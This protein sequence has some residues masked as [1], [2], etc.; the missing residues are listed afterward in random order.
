MAAMDTFLNILEENRKGVRRG[1]YSVCSSQ[2]EV[3]LAAL[4]QALEDQGPVIIES[5]SNQVDQFG[6]Y[7]GMT[8]AGFIAFVENL[9][10]R[11]GFPRERLLFGGD[12]LG[13]NRWQGLKAETAM[14]H[15]FKLVNDYVR[16]GYRK[17]H[18]DASMFCADDP[19]DRTK[20]LDD[21]IVARRA[22]ALC[23]V[24]EDAWLAL[25]SPRPAP[26][27]IIGTEVPVPGGAR[28]AEETVAVTSPEAAKQTLETT[29]NIFDRQ[30]LSGVW[31]RVVGLVVQPGVEFQDTGVF[32]YSRQNARELSSLVR[33]ESGF[34]F[35]AHST[36]YQTGLSLEEMVEDHFCILK[37]GPWLTY[38]FREALFALEMVERELLSGQ[39]TLLSGLTETLERA[40]LAR[41]EFWNKYYPGTAEEQRFKRRYSFSDRSRYYWTDP[42]LKQARERLT[43]NLNRQPLPLSLL[44]QFLPVQYEAVREGRLQSVPE[45]LIQDRIGQVLRTYSRACGLAPNRER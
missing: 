32:S 20:P 8:P 10:H 11:A 2:E 13:P 43:A 44:S 16:A 26:V 40:M 29:R 18:L 17:I 38:A 21:D 27:Y 3:I 35:E 4:E 34:V 45:A 39:G 22:A 9:A 7:T 28:E 6:G 14:E 23:R 30:G 42:E 19:G 37:V 31:E 12:H 33:Q 24:S 41:P 5:T 15:A 25:G 36:D 1:V